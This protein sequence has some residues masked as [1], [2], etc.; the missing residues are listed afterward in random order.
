[1]REYVTYGINRNLFNPDRIEIHLEHGIQGKPD[2]AWW[3]SPVDA[4]YGW[5]EWCLGEDFHTESYFDERN[6]ILW[7]FQP[8][9]NIITI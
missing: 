3:G 1:M 9:T 4:H 8:D 7:T 5:K 2:C 6:K